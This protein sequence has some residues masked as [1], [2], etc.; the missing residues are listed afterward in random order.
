MPALQVDEEW[1][2]RAAWRS[3]AAS[4]RQRDIVHVPG[5]HQAARMRVDDMPV[6]INLP[7]APNPRYTADLQEADALIG[8]GWAAEHLP[9]ALG[10]RV[11]WVPKGV[12]AEQFR[13]DGPNV[14]ERLGLQRKRVVIAV[15]RLAP[16]KNLRLLLDAI[17]VPRDRAPEF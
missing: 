16:L 17:P 3:I 7:G 1:F 15:A 5:V 4:D 11:E 10:R 13:P 14:R 6:V 2:C 9:A 8:D 12:D